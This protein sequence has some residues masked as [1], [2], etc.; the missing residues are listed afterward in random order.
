MRKAGNRVRI[1]AQLVDVG[2]GGRIWA[3]QL[4]NRELTDVFAVQDEVT[5]EIVAALALNLTIGEQQQLAG[6]HT[7]SPEAYDCFL[8]GRELWHLQ[9]KETNAEARVAFQ[10]AI[11][12]DAQNLRPLMRCSRL[13][14]CATTSISG[15]PRLHCPWKKDTKSRRR[16]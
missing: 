5:W 10:R 3:E 2:S 1:T 11:E 15:P 9:T 12:L 16:R 4:T 6:E 7:S 13:R 14:T 8:R